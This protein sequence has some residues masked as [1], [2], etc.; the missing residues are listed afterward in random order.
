MSIDPQDPAPAAPA[1]PAAAPVTP[2]AA[3]AAP[4]APAKPAPA[5]PGDNSTIRTMREAMS[6]KDTENAE[7]QR[8][9]AEAQGKVT[10]ADRKDMAD[11]ERT[12]AERDDA[13]DKLKG[14][15]DAKTELAALSAS[16]EATYKSA[17]EAVDEKHRENVETLSKEGNWADR[18]TKLNAAI[19]ILPTPQSVGS[20]GSPS[21]PAA[22]EPAPSGGAPAAPEPLGPEG[23]KEIAKQDGSIGRYLM[24]RADVAA[25]RAK[26]SGNNP[27]VVRP[28]EAAGK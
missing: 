5:A 4:A 6:A 9:L 10:D 1:A 18:L 21:A 14:H 27:T 3:P 15:E 8:Q 12:T 19:A 11:L 17:L 22:P 13:L 7:L 20:S 25:A 2:A 28:E 26:L 23:L 16:M 24:P